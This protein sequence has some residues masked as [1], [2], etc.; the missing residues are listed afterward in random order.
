MKFHSVGSYLSGA[1][2]VS[3]VT[4]P[5]T[6]TIDHL[7]PDP[8]RRSATK[9]TAQRQAL[10]LM[11]AGAPAETLTINLH[12]LVEN[13]DPNALPSAYIAADSIWFTFDTAVVLTAGT[14]TQLVWPTDSIPNGGIIYAERTA[15][16]IAGAATRNLYV[17]WS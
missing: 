3:P 15:D 5:A 11:F 1:A 4:N 9:D 8:S 2:D 6:I 12:L 16:T 17:A 14:L 13:K 7:F 10:S